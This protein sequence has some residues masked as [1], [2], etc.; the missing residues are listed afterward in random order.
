MR[1]GSGAPCGAR[2]GAVSPA[3]VPATG[4]G[5]TSSTVFGPVD[6]TATKGYALP[7]PL[8]IAY[9]AAGFRRQS[10]TPLETRRQ[11]AHIRTMD[12]KDIPRRPL[13]K[14]G[15]LVDDA[16]AE[17]KRLGIDTEGKRPDE[18]LKMAREERNKPRV[19]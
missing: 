3:P 5:T 16:K 1:S 13:P 9:L 18:I 12:T 17:L 19:A 7:W 10:R 2:S 11:R 4:R 6:R 14:I 8:A 15:Q